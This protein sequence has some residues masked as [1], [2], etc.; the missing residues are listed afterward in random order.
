MAYVQKE[1]LEAD[2]VMP[3]SEVDYQVVELQ[4][5]ESEKPFL[6]EKDNGA[7]CCDTAAVSHPI[8]TS[9]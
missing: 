2:V 3:G 4:P 9:F 8:I 7:L 6:T 1:M 5:E